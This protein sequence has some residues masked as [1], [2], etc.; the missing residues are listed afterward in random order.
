MV[1]MAT[2]QN[3]EH[4]HALSQLHA[5]QL[6]L[7]NA[8]ISM[9]W[10]N[11][12]FLEQDGFEARALRWW[13]DA[14]IG[15]WIKTNHQTMVRHPRQ[16]TAVTRL[17]RWRR[18]KTWLQVRLLLTMLQD[19]DHCDFWHVNRYWIVLTC[20][21]TM[22][23]RYASERSS[24]ELA[25]SGRRWMTWSKEAVDWEFRGRWLTLQTQFS[26]AGVAMSY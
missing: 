3:L 5:Q 26:R 23:V 15:V 24:G 14:S 21:T 9:T 12:I 4:C 17:P 22:F 25:F 10:W 7:L 2:K 18:R 13:L 19:M 6:L 11:Y 16:V 1:A 20:D 8:T